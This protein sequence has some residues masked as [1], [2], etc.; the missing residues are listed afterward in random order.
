MEFVL[1]LG[2][3]AFGAGTDGFGIV[4]VEGAG[5]FGV[6]SVR[7]ERVVSKRICPLGEG[8]DPIQL[9]PVLVNPSNEQGHAKRPTH[10]ALL[11]LGALTEPQ[12]QVANRLRAALN[13]QRLV[14]V[15]SVILALDAGVLDHGA[16]ISL[17]AGHGAADVAVYFDDLF[18]RGGFEESGG[19]AFFD[20]EDYAGVCGDLRRGKRVSWGDLGRKDV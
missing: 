20:A 14:V 3:G 1:Q 15:E 9:R 2:L 8:G 18:D 5:G 4:A 13:P 19:N 11:A 7:G 17:Q 12:R 10:N 16:G 6:V